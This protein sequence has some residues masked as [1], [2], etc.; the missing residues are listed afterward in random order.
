[1][2]NQRR[3]GAHFLAESIQDEARLLVVD[4]QEDGLVKVGEERLRLQTH[5]V[6]LEGGHSKRDLQ[7]KGK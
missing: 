5:H 2:Q 1:M 7:T 6:L 3:K 4:G